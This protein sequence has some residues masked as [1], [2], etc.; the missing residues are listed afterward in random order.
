MTDSSLRLEKYK[1]RG[2]LS[3]SAER[4]NGKGKEGKEKLGACEKEI[5]V[6]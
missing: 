2:A 6:S 3:P 1:V 5:E 4:G